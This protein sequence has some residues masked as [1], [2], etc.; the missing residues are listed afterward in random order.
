[1]P[2]DPQGLAV[3]G[4]G[5][6]TAFAAW[7]SLSVF[8]RYLKSR[9]TPA[10]LI[11]LAFFLNFV[12]FPIALWT[13]RYI[14]DGTMEAPEILVSVLRVVSINSIIASTILYGVFTRM[15]FRRDSSGATMFL[16]CVG[17]IIAV[18]HQMLLAAHPTT[19]LS[20][21]GPRATFV[22]ATLAELTIFGWL[23]YESLAMWKKYKNNS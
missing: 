17:I 21:E 20:Y 5:V 1:M 16:V 6:L 11:A 23:T 19:V 15:V 8:R 4:M 14:T 3:I 22:I 7:T 10:L 18:C 9:Y 2:S 12:I 13:L